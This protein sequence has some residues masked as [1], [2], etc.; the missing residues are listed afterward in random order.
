MIQSVREIDPAVLMVETLERQICEKTGGA[1]RDL[2]V[3]FLDDQI[4]VNGRTSR[5]YNKQL[6]TTAVRELL[7]DDHLINR[8][9]VV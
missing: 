5:Y 7:Q 8:I 1:I 2:H 3:E 9:E 4:V 6:A